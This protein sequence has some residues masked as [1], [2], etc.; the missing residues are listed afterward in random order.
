MIEIGTAPKCQTASGLP[1]PVS[2]MRAPRT[3]SCEKKP[4]TE[5]PKNVRSECEFAKP[6]A[7]A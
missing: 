1:K 3:F 7:E 6:D 5:Q 4:A 2:I